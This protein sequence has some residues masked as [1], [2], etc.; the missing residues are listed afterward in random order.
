MRSSL[1]TGWIGSFTNF[2]TSETHAPVDDPTHFLETALLRC[3]LLF[4]LLHFLL[5]S[6]PLII[7]LLLAAPCGDKFWQRFG[8]DIVVGAG[9]DDAEDR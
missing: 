6:T 9:V 5:L 2:F 7:S 3:L 4:L 8:A 1:D